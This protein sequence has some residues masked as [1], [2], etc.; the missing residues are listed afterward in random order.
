MN[1]SSFDASFAFVLKESVSNLPLAALGLVF[2]AGAFYDAYKGLWRPGGIGSSRDPI[3]ASWYL[4]T[5][6]LLAGLWALY[7]SY[8]LLRH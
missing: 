6:L 8:I 1:I 3:K 7:V 2:A 5:F 4:R